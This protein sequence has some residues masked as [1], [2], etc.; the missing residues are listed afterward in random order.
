MYRAWGCH[1]GDIEC[2]IFFTDQNHTVHWDTRLHERIFANKLGNLRQ[3]ET[4]DDL[5]HLF[6]VPHVPTPTDW[7]SV[8]ARTNDLNPV[9]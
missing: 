5:G 4:R 7:V 8:L 2:F 1:S 6:H 9:R 3:I